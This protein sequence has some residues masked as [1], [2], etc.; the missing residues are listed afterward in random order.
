MVQEITSLNSFFNDI[1]VDL[2]CHQD[3]KAYITSIFSRHHSASFDLSKDSITLI[4][5]EAKN[6][7]DFATFQKVADWIFFSKSFTPEHLRAASEEYYY[8]IGK[9][10]YYN[11]Y[12]LINGKWRLFEELS[13]NF[14]TLEKETRGILQNIGMSR[15]FID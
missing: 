1:F 8:N 11:C 13:D 6:N 4:F 5:S 9:L 15:L 3:T 10:S 2:K 7:Q 12:K 14:I